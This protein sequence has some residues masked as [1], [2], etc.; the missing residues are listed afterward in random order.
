[1]VEILGVS[2][3]VEAVGA[4]D[5]SHPQAHRVLNAPPTAGDEPPNGGDGKG[6]NPNEGCHPPWGL[7]VEA[8]D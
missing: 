7:G 8:A 5:V 4:L 2:E 6:K 1:M 3:G